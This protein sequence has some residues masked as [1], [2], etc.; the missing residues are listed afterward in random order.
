MSSPNMDASL[1]GSIKEVHSLSDQEVSEMFDL[2]Q[3]FFGVEGPDTFRADLK[4]KQYVIHLTDGKGRV[5]GFST[6]TG[7]A[8]AF[9]DREI[10]VIYSGDTI[11]CPE[12]WGTSLLHK[13][14]LEAVMKLSGELPRPL[15][16]FLLSSGYK[17][18]R[19]LPVFFKVF[20]PQYDLKTEPEVQE[21][22]DVLAQ[23]QFGGLYS[24]EKG[25]VQFERGVTPLREGVSEVDEKRLKDPHVAFFL[26][27]NPGHVRG[28]ELV[29]LTELTDDNVS[30]AGRRIMKAV[31]VDRLS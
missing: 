7:Y 29:C 21:L 3:L 10:G 8:T 12:H 2:F 16:W 19:F 30:R 27:K 28:D 14:W 11:V 6:I 22:V 23:R 24:P 17:T 20:H 15:Y 9:K 4:R 5:Q 25:I 31:G 1:T 26:E 13:M 18:Y